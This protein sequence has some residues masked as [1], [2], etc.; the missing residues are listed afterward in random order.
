MAIV[1]VRILTFDFGKSIQLLVEDAKAD[2]NK[3]KQGA[4]PADIAKAQGHSEVVD[5][6]VASGGKLSASPEPESSS[7]SE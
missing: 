6:L 5:Y 7:K 2:V 4:T 1:K 3:G